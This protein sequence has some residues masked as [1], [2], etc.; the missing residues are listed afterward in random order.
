MG[1]YQAVPLPIHIR[2]VRLVAP[3]RD[4]IT[5]KIKDTVVKHLRGG[6]PF[7]EPVYGTNTPKHTRYIA[8][9]D[10]PVPWPK[11]ERKDFQA[12][13]ADTLAVDVNYRSFSPSVLFLPLP[14]SVVDEIRNK[15]SWRRTGHTQEYVQQKIREDAEEQWKKRRRMLLPQQE[16][17]ERQAKQKE[18][19]G[20][21]EVTKETTDLIRNMQAATL[22]APK[23][24]RDRPVSTVS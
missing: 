12:E 7:V 4:N 1:P 3:L 19:R 11:D 13:T 6:K 24:P 18:A 9:L 20:K 5:G 22:G 14:D 23:Q 17:W 2:D 16:Y 8:G 15:Y 10:I 21:P